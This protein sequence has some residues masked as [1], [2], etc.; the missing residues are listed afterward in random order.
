MP[1]TNAAPQ[2]HTTRDTVLGAGAGGLIGH[3]GEGEH[4]TARDAIVGGF[5]GHE[6]GHFG[7]DQHKNKAA[8]G[9]SATDKI[10]GTLEKAAGKILNKPN[11]VAEGE[12]KRTG[13]GA[14]GASG[15]Y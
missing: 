13:M 6:A 1:G 4:H 5:V 14:T 7:R 15:G 11:L 8:G 10:E 12:A 2:D 9:P 3:H